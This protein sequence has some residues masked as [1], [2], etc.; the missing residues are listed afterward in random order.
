MKLFLWETFKH[1]LPPNPPLLILT[2]LTWHDWCNLRWEILLSAQPTVMNVRPDVCNESGD[3]W[4]NLGAGERG[5]KKDRSSMRVRIGWAKRK[6]REISKV[7][8]RKRTEEG[9]ERQQQEGQQLGEMIQ[10]WEEESWSE[11]RE[12]A[13]E[14]GG[15]PACVA[16]Q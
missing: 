5:W 14:C 11:R 1:F 2:D 10:G 6:K 15:H 3:G 12:L 7:K 13:S 8:D 16:S 9:G 4:R